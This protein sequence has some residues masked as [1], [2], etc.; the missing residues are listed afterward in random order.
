[1]DSYH[2]RRSRSFRGAEWT[3]TISGVHKP[4][5]RVSFDIARTRDGRPYEDELLPLDELRVA[6]V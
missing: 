1:M 2:I 5:A 3:A 4:T 6:V